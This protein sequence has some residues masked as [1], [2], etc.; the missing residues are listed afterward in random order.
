MDMLGLDASERDND[1]Q[2]ERVKRQIRVGWLRRLAVFYG[3]AV[4]AYYRRR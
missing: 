2:L 1:E 3:A 4:A